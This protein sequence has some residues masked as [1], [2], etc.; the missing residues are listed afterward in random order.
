MIKFNLVF[1]IWRY[2]GISL[3]IY[4]YVSVLGIAFVYGYILE[5]VV[6]M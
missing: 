6:I 2:I 1:D 4:I 5:G 3:L